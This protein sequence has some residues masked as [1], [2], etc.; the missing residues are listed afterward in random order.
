MF[1][2]LTEYLI[3]RSMS[4]ICDIANSSEANPGPRAPERTPDFEANLTQWPN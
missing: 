3:F 2:V 1:T 4:M